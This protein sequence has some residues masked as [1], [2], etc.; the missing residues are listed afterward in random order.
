MI[1]EN[2]PSSYLVI[3]IA[4]LIAFVFLPGLYILSH[5]LFLLIKIEI[6]SECYFVELG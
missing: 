5:C 4:V 2:Q 1:Y 3:I 6:L